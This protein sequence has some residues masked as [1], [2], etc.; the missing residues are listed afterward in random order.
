M[1]SHRSRFSDVKAASV[2]LV[3]AACALWSSR[4]NAQACCAGTGVVT[5]G[6]LA[7]WERALVGM[8]VKAGV[9]LGSYDS[10]GHYASSPSGASEQDFEEDLFAAYRVLPRGQV[11]LLVPIVETRRT[12][13]GASEIGGGFGD[14]N[15]SGRY[16]FTSAGDSQIVPGIAA[17]A[18]VTFPT[19]TP[20]DAP[21]LGPLATGATGVGAFQ[22]N[23]GLAVEQIFGP[24][25]VNATLVLAQRT[26]RTVGS[27]ATSVH[28]RLGAQWTALAAVAYVFKSEAALAMSASYTIEGDA[29][30]GGL[31]TSGTAHRLPTVTLSGV[32][33]IADGWR[34]QGAL[35][36]NLPV[37]QL[38]LNQPAGAGLSLTLVRSWM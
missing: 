12:A 18:G 11:A 33:P 4:A 16:D 31:D 3:V 27:G 1:S 6:R 21:S 36:D 19:G 15:L 9:N 32:L 38:G 17:L 28:E 29:T 23:A 13:L 34:A 22:V 35:Y 2:A 14:V 24:W 5:P 37:S 30:I 7:A 8:Q 25:L 20:P 26:A 10:G